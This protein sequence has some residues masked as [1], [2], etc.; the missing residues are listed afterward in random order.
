M[1]RAH[2]NPKAFEVSIYVPIKICNCNKYSFKYF[3]TINKFL[4]NTTIFLLDK[5]LLLLK[6]IGNARPGEGD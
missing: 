2:F 6:K 3:R 4:P 5:L 1:P